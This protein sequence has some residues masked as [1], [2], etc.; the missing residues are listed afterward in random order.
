[1]C[2][3]KKDL[4]IEML[5]ILHGICIF[6]FQFLTCPV[7]S[8]STSF[9]KRYSMH[10]CWRVHLLVRR[11]EAQQITYQN[12]FNFFNYDFSQSFY[13]QV[14]TEDKIQ[15]VQDRIQGLKSLIY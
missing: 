12:Y 8:I 6:G 15:I 14:F 2:I 13:Y 5:D 10:I 7:V 11:L 1:M 9:A 3:T 4:K